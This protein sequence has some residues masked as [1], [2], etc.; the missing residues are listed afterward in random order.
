MSPSDNAPDIALMQPVSEHEPCGGSLEYDPEYAVLLARLMPGTE[1]QYGHFVGVPEAPNWTDVERDCRRLLRRTKDINLLVWLCRARTRLAQAGGLVQMLSTLHAM[2]QTW[3]DAIHPQASI[4]GEHDPAVRANALAALVDPE[5]LLGD[6]REVAAA[7]HHLR[8]SVRDVE[9]ALAPRR[10]PD[11]P[12]AEIV[13][14]QLQGLR[15]AAVGD[16]LAPVNLLAQAARIVC[17]IQAWIDVHLRDEGPSL[18]PLVRLLQP[19]AMPTVSLTVAPS[20]PLHPQDALPASVDDRAKGAIA[21][22]AA[23][24]STREDMR[25]SICAARGWFE[26]H[27]PSSPVA[28]LLKQA[29]RMVGKRFHEI[30]DAIPLDLLRQWETADHGN[31]SES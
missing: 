19:F 27:E 2:L 25:R 23:A 26:R 22:P 30:A 21:E 14:R 3:P 28:V 7:T 29:E 13:L 8:L 20:R 12:D 9:R 5:G 17:D 18:A 24:A 10:A 16:A 11:A 6:L 31:G 4:E 1:A 15:M